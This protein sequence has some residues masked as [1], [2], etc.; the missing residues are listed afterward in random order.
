M[1]AAAAAAWCGCLQTKSAGWSVQGEI[2]VL[3]ANS[4]NTAVQQKRTQDLIGFDAVAPVLKHTVT[5]V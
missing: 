3:P 2:V 1:F 4:F 5:A